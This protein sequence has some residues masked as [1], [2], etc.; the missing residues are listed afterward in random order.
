MQELT[1]DMLQAEYK[2]LGIEEPQAPAAPIPGY[3]SAEQYCRKQPRKASSTIMNRCRDLRQRG[4]IRGIQV[5]RQWFYRVEDLDAYWARFDTPGDYVHMREISSW[6][7]EV[8]FTTV[9]SR[10]GILTRKGLLDTIAG[11]RYR[12]Y[13]KEG[14]YEKLVAAFGGPGAGDA[15][16]NS[17][18]RVPD[19]VRDN[20][21][22]RRK[23]ATK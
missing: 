7:P 8:S 9:S 20:R 23:T 19:V 11:G 13:K 3:L 1:L 12:S 6:F 16:C 17:S 18:D 15:G 21:L 22:A 4:L 5:G 2:R 10:V 14:L